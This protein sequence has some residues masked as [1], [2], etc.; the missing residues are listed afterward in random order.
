M[1]SLFYRNT[2]LLIL[3]LILIMVWGIASFHTLP[4]L[5]DPEL[6]SRNATVTTFLPGADS[7]RIEALVTEKIEDEIA[8]IE[9][10]LTYESTSRGGVSVIEI[11]LS[12]QVTDAEV[13]S[14]WSRVR[15][16]L[17][18]AALEFPIGATDP[19]L[20]EV[21][22]KAYALVIALTWERDD[23]PNYT[24]L[25]RLAASLKD[26]LDAL[27][28]T[29]SV[30]QFGE[31][32]EEIVVQVDPARLAGLGLS[33]QT[34]S[35]QL[36]Q[37]DAKTAAGQLRGP[38]NDVPLEIDS[39][40]DS[41]N[42]LARTP[43]QFGDRGQFVV[44]GD[45]AQIEK[46]A[47][48]PLQEMAIA[49]GKPAVAL[50]VFV[51]SNYRLDQ[52]AQQAQP[53]LEEVR[54]QLSDG[55]TLHILFDQTQ[56]VT[57]RLNTLILNLLLG[58]AL[59]F[60]VTLVMM[61]W[62]SSVIVST[63][64]PL[65]LLMV[66]GLMGLLGIPLHQIS[67]TGLIVALGIL[68]DT[69][70]VM[71]DEVRHHLTHGIPPEG[72][73]NRSVQ[74]LAIPLLS[75]TITTVLAF[76]PIALL[77]G[78]V[79]E[80]VGTIGLNV[81]LAVSCSLLLSITVVPALAAHLF[82]GWAH[83]QS[84][85]GRPISTTSWWRDGITFPAIA[86]LYERVL[87]QIIYRPLMSIALALMLPLLGF[88]QAPFLE[89]QFFPAS[90][91]D[92]LQIELELSPSASIQ[93]TQDTVKVIRDRLLQ[94]EQVEEIHWFV[95][96][97]AP[98]FYYNL[99]GGRENE[100]NYAQA[101]VQLNQLS[102]AETTRTLQA[103]IDSDFP[104]VRAI[105]RQLEQGPPFDAP[106]EVR[107]AGQDL[108]QLQDL[109]ER[110]REQLVQIDA[111]THTRAS[112]NETLPQLKLVLNEN[113]ARLTGLDNEAI[114]QQLDQ[115]LEGIRGGS[116][117]E[118]TE[119][120]PVRVRI[121]DRSNLDQIAALPLIS[122]ST[123]T[124]IPLST[125][126]SLTLEPETAKITHYNGQRVNTI[127]G[128]IQ[129]GVLPATVLSQLQTQF[130]S[131][132]IPLPPDYNLAFGGEAEERANAI[133]NLVSTI[134]V[135][136]VLI[137]ATLVLSLR[138]FK[139]AGLIGVVAIASFGLGLLSVALFG[140]PF[141][142]NPIIGIVGLIGVA[143]ND[144]IVVMSALHEHPNARM[145]HPEAIC[146]VVSQ[147]TR[148]VLTTTFTTMIGFVP[149]LLD[150][151]EF[152]PPLAV[153]IAGGVGGATLLTLLFVPAAYRLTRYNVRGDQQTATA[154]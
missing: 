154:L 93:Q 33:P 11:E 43:I 54:N 13:S 140:Y 112:L 21:E 114:A 83:R 113:A 27:P 150:G 23:A 69:A 61:G 106:I 137:V 149:L 66:L 152:W 141:G 10:I 63:A 77:P 118:E 62:Q 34:L 117:L 2:R 32:N 38:T 56:Y 68:I 95:G 12:E 19:E 100:A 24:I 78:S 40:L 55:L 131:N 44:L 145:G 17:D 52:W 105:V 29:E 89:Q 8:E 3:I 88:L 111:V 65:S 153:A 151:G 51:Q 70:I 146:A 46:G 96:T 148:H 75:S 35:L 67:I 58:A 147:S 97:N 91:R 5:E 121:A 48:E 123:D 76:M 98:R 45:I 53:I 130:Q 143:I 108:T 126:G 80:F 6:V 22:V 72:A 127:Q 20:E 9:E 102:S 115:T 15:D 84:S 119:E 28:G 59:V 36:V 50:G 16:K 42:R 82:E 135:L 103:Q 39:E 71:V 134:G 132:P 31:P 49:S 92:Q 129:A 94:N 60:G 110:V 18:D 87:N 47:F 74:H 144:S 136:T 86:R 133:S 90:D 14:I 4:R 26:R 1:F 125:L 79:G 30:D 116:I 101:L 73:I 104:G 7:E 139:L 128:F 64:L 41:L 37:T 99:T 85:R 138:S 109:G 81:I 25:R 57:T 107:I 120:L 142:F 124:W 122:E